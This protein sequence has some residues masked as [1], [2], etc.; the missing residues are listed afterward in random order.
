MLPRLDENARVLRAAYLMLADDVHRGVFVTPASE[1]LLYY[2]H[3]VAAVLLEIRRNLPRAYYRSLPK[4]ALRELAGDARV[5]AMAVELIRHSDSRLDRQQL[6]RFMNSYQ[7]VAP[8]TIGELWAWPSM[9]K[10]ALVE[11]LRRLAEETLLARDARRAADADVASVDTGGPDPLPTLKG[12]IQHTAYVVQLLQRVREYGPR[13]ASVRAAVDTHLA[14]EDTTWE[15]AIRTEHQRQAAAQVSVSNVVTSLRLCSNLDWSQFFESVSHVERVLQRDPSGAYA[16]MDF[17]SRDRYRQ[18]VEE[19]AEPSGE[20]QLRVALRAV[21][22]ARQALDSGLGDRAG[23]IGHHLI[24]KGRRDLETDLAYRPTPKRRLRRSLYAHATGAYLGAVILGTAGLL[25]LGDLTLRRGGASP[26][27]LVLGLLLL[28]L[29]ASELV[30]SFLQR[31]AARLAPPR[32]LPRLEFPNGVPETA[33]TMV[34]VPTLLSSVEVAKSLVEHLE[35]LALGNLDA[36]IHFAI[37]SDFTDA[38]MS[39]MPEDAAILQ[40]ARDGIIALNQGLGDAPGRFH[41]FHRV[42]Q[43]NP[44]EGVWMGWER[45][46]GKLEEFNSL[47]RGDEATSFTER[48]GDPDVLPGVRY[49]LTLDSDTRLPRD[50]ARKLIGILSH[51]LNR[52][53]FDPTKGRVTEG[54][55]I[56]QPR[57]SVTMAS[58]AGSLFARLYAGHTG[59]DPYTTAVSDTYQDLFAEGIFT[60]KGLY[61]VDAF[62]SALAN[63]VPENSLLSH[64]L[65]EGVYARTA[66]VTDVEVVD[67]YPGSVL[68]HARR[69]HRWVRGD[70]QIL[71]WLFPFVPSPTGLQRN[72]LPLISR[73]KIFD[74]LRRSLIPP[75]QV[76]LLVGAWVAL[77]EHAAAFTLALV[78]ALA[79]PIYPLLL[80]ILRGPRPH[81]SWPVLLHVLGEDLQTSLG[82]V[83][84]Q[85]TFLASDA[86]QRVHAIGVTIVRVFATRRRMLE[87]ETAAAS[88]VRA[89]RLGSRGRALLFFTEMVASPAMAVACLVVLALVRPSSLPI[90]LPIVSL[91]LAAPFVAYLLSRPVPARKV[92]LDEDERKFLHEVAERTWRY[93]ETF[94]GPEDNGLPPDNFQEIPDPRI[95][96]RTSPTNMGMGLL[97]TLAAHDLELVDTDALV[98]KVGLTLSTMEGLERYEGHLLNWYDTQ[99]LAPLLP[100]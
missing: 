8:L 43:W 73:W 44:A 71:R 59:V 18:A 66:L 79:F 51:P 3:L 15:D 17:L 50:A 11:N 45:K 67:D 80:G 5:Y 68:A 21:E 70:W 89:A 56:L 19:L 6:V 4:L 81:Q 75:A 32:R 54:Y 84:L 97:A 64:D 53:F 27:E 48:V 94:M 49:V 28:L 25:A 1:W 63:K 61:D 58:A 2:Y 62:R 92:S 16:R 93:F 85:I 98:A 38:P 52:P 95:A 29:P 77:P 30:I 57:V 47:L 88:A 42:R 35:V 13:L 87:W 60:G 86:Y 10:L 96:H 55:G 83:A 90:A 14:A 37:L 76:A 74:N 22:S 34:V 69:L 65:F 82:Q 7:T 20:A 26:G 41:L 12:R 24:G 46:R 40:A 36:Q 39:E 33:R 99:T 72:Q 9:L 100:R 91:W 31:A 78:A 23:H